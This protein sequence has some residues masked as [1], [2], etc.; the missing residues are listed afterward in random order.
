MASG[1]LSIGMSPSGDICCLHK[2]GSGTVAPQILKELIG[3]VAGKVGA[4]SK[5][6]KGFIAQEGSGERASD[7]LREENLLVK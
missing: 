5:V 3:L 1:R 6:F 4:V 7:V 2:S